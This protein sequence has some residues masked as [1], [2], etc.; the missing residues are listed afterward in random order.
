LVDR[1]GIVLLTPDP[2]RI[3]ERIPPAEVAAGQ[4]IEIDDELV[5]AV[6]DTKDPT[7]RNPAEEA[8]L[9]RTNRVLLIGALSGA[10]I[11]LILGVLVA[12]TLTGPLR[13][14]TRASR[15]MA[16]GDLNR[17]VTVRSRDELGELALAFNQM[18]ADLARADQQR[19]QMTA[20]IAHDLRTP[21]TVLSG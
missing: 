8:Y 19:Q 16:A 9:I 17:Q 10:V 20:D 13:D 11:A 4:P 12:R 3:G 6:L 14:L 2:T 7:P 15:A 5:G 18:S 1:N 21:L